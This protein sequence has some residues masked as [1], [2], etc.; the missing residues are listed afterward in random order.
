MEEE[1]LYQS[2]LEVKNFKKGTESIGPLL[3][4]LYK[5]YKLLNEF[6]IFFV[7][8]PIHIWNFNFYL[9]SI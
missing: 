4:Y 6:I 8:W 3:K 5:F 1:K 9:Y 2:I 7:L